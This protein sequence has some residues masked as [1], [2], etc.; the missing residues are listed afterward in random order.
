MA[1]RKARVGEKVTRKEGKV[2]LYSRQLVM[3]VGTRVVAVEV[4]LEPLDLLMGCIW[5]VRE[6]R[7]WLQVSVVLETR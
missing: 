4:G 7:E 2:W 3:V 6:D 1:G 5:Q